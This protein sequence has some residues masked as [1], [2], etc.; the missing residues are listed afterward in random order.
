MNKNR[1][2]LYNRVTAIRGV[3]FQHQKNKTKLRKFYPEN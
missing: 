3:T 1:K 2:V